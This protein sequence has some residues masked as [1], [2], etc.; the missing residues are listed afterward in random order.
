M[1]KIVLS[2][3]C[4]MAAGTLSVKAQVEN[5]KIVDTRS[6]NTVLT[7]V[8]QMPEFP[9]GLE[10]M[11]KFLSSNL[12]YPPRAEEMGIKGRVTCQFIVETD[13]S[14]T[15]VRVVRGVDPDLDREAMRVIKA[16]P[17]WIP[18]KKDGKPVR[19]RFT[20][21]VNFTL[22]E[23][24]K[25]ASEVK[26]ETT[27]NAAP[28]EHAVLEMVEQMPSF[29]GGDT[30]MANYLRENLRYPP[31][32]EEMGIKGRVT[33]SFIIEPDGLVTNVKVERG[34]DPNLDNEAVRVLYRMPNWI[35][36][37]S[38]GKPVRVRYTCPINFTLQ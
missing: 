9:G 10:A 38:G 15:D 26:S 4:L 23:P 3:L 36:G 13:G 32:A 28:S 31:E 34:V 37:K 7:V 18:G 21:P 1:K 27:P 29:P 8:D 30:A 12:R 19:V 14:I 25:Q 11:A 17:K 2:L 24:V 33:C 35:P 20:S 6:E 5:K 16:M 22:A